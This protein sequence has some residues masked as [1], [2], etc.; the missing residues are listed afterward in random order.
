MQ[1]NKQ[2]T[3]TGTTS[4]LPEL[5]SYI[6]GGVLVP[7]VDREN[8]LLNPNDLQPLQ[9][10]L[11]CSEQ[12]VETALAAADAAYRDGTW[13]NTPAAERADVIDAIADTLQE[14]EILEN[15]ARADAVTTGAVIN[16][17]RKM[18]QLA[19]FVFRNAAQ[20][21]RDGNLERRL[22]GKR[23]EVEYFRRPWGP[24][25]LVSPWN[26]PTAIG[27]HMAPPPSHRGTM[28]PIVVQVVSRIGRRRFCADSRTARWGESPLSSISM[29]MRSS[30]TMALLITMPASEMMP[31]SVMK[32][33]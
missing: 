23:G 16:V 9:A 29:R 17:T 12:Q 26:G 32:P 31:R 2:Q 22:P 6:D 5:R 14:P 20:Y 30:S 18:A 19:P 24:A 27:S 3:H 21:L 7:A 1:H 8:I 13:E 28:P 15:I 11:S 25:L 4:S 10:Q 33:K